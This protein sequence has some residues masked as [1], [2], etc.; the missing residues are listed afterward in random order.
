MISPPAA[1]GP[2]AQAS[3][4]AWPLPAASC[5]SSRRSIER[6]QPLCVVSQLLARLLRDNIK[7]PRKII[8]A[9]PH[10]GT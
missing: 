9:E 2:L 8:S 7:Y 3:K 4:T 5:G 10:R 1:C 6:C